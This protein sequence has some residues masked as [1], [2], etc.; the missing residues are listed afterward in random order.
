VAL[1]LLVLPWAWLLRHHHLDSGAVGLVATFP[2]GLPALWLGIAG[3]LQ[4][5]RS[6]QV[7]IADV[8][9]QLASAV[10]AQWEAEARIRRLNAPY[11]LPVSWTAADTTLT[12]DWDLLERLG[13][14]GAGW[15]RP[16]APGIWAAGPHELAAGDNELVSV[17]AR[18]PTG[19]LVV[20]GEPGAGKTTL[21]VR[22]DE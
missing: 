8:A 16:A 19:R 2:F 13:R 10:S 5:G 7:T 18:V 3:Y 21:V 17:L 1:V 4:A 11:P 22:L 12:D 9:D 15:P 20:L 6:A 14:S